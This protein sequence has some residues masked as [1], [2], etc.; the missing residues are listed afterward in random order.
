[1]IADSPSRPG[2]A[3]PSARASALR[4]AFWNVVGLVAGLLLTGIVGEAWL[5]L[6]RPF[7]NSSQ[8]YVFVPDVGPLHEPGSQVRYT[9]GRD[10]WTTSRASRWGFVDR[11]PL[12][13]E[14]ARAGCHVTLIGDSLVE[15]LEVPVRDKVQVRLESLARRSV[16][17]LDVTVSAF[18]RGGTGQINQLPFYDV[19]ARRL[20]PKLVVLVVFHNDFRNNVADRMALLGHDPHLLPWWSAAHGADGVFKLLPPAADY[21]EGAIPLGFSEDPFTYV[22]G[23]VNRRSWL[24]KWA[25]QGN[26]PFGAFY[27]RKVQAKVAAFL[28]RRRGH[29]R[30]DDARHDIMG[31]ALDQFKMRADRDGAALV[32]LATSHLFGSRRKHF[33]ALRA[34]A[35]PRGIPVI[36]QYAYIVRQGG[37][38]A[39]ARWPHDVHWSRAGHRWAAQALLEWLRRH[40]EVCAAR[41]R[42]RAVDVSSV[43]HR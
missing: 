6:Q 38:P 13:P 30:M 11:G 10:F 32:V 20:H 16:P 24:V 15:A 41:D 27:N 31:F 1:M 12:P 21:R 34:L 36:D 22:F 25:L 2:Q 5:R 17:L 19:Y 9:N 3:R 18:G 39:D 4:V 14:R 7:M 42:R 8:S 43:A 33:E 40:E 29:A 26:N 28:K 37:D 23:A 35:E